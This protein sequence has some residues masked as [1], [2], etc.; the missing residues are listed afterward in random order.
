MIIKVISGAQTGADQAGLEAAK[1]VG[2]ETGGCMPKG[3]ITLDGP[4]T[5][6]KELYGVVEHTSPKYPPRTY[7]NVKNSDATIRF[8]IDF[9]TAGELCTYAAIKEYDKLH[10]DVKLDKSESKPNPRSVKIVAD[11]IIEKQVK[12]LN[13]AGNSSKK[14]PF[15]QERVKQFLVEVFKLVKEY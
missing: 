2:F 5:D 9:G 7:D 8:A 3:F 6:F 11:W 10:L 14:Y 13:I 15:I 1:E 4:R 12:V